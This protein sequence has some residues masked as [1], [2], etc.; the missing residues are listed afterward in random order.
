MKRSSNSLEGATSAMAAE[1]TQILQMLAEGKITV[2]EAERLLT[3]TVGE[4]EGESGPD[5]PE[6]AAR[7]GPKYI[8]VVVEPRS[9][10]GDDA[11]KDG[12]RVNVRVPIAIIRAGI[13]LTSLI[14]EEASE[15]VNE[16]LSKKGINFDV[17][18]L[19]EKSLTELVNAMSELEVDVSNPTH[20]VRVFTE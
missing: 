5:G 3:L 6:R 10:A 11:G 7:R 19:D 15:Q 9:E 17:R 4:D 8:R 2:E 16:A 12:E 13:K 20:H 18:K 14:P 1:R